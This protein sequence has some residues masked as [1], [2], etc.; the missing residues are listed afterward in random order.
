MGLTGASQWMYRP[1]SFFRTIVIIY[2]DS[3]I[4][5]SG[6]V[7]F[8]RLF[9]AWFFILQNSWHFRTRGNHD[10]MMPSTDILQSLWSTHFR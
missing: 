8:S 5:F 6:P 10:V 4:T 7:P 2:Q 9:R 1:N 3:Y